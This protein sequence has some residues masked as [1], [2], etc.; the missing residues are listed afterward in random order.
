[1]SHKCDGCYNKNDKGDYPICELMWYSTLEIA[2]GRCELPG[3][4]PEYLSIELAEKIADKLNE[5]PN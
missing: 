1:M 5:I 3:P 4:C 2:K